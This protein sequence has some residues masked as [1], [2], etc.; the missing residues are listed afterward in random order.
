MQVFMCWRY[1]AVS[2]F[3]VWFFPGS[4]S[5]IKLLWSSLD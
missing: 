1:S 2:P 4:E 3:R 5:S